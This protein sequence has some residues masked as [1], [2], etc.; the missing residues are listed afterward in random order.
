[1]DKEETI[2][3]KERKKRKTK[4]EEFDGARNYH[5][6]IYYNELNYSVIEIILV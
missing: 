5:I 2:T 3:G 6:V 4:G 1:M